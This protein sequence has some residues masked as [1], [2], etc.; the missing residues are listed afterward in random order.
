MRKQWYL[1]IIKHLVN[2]SRVNGLLLHIRYTKKL[3]VPK[4]NQLTLHQFTRG[5]ADALL[6][7]QGT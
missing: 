6:L 1:E 2:I 7:H 3:A 5:V 4:Q